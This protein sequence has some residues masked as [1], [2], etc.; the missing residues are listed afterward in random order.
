MS[1]RPRKAVDSS[2]YEGRF[3][4]RL[5]QLREKAGLMPEEVAEAVGVDQRTIYRWESG[6]FDPQIRHL[7]LLAAK[8]G[9]EVR[10]LLPKK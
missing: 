8:F 1:P 6:K 5:K 3:A 4:M 2:T 10:T 9:I 7:P